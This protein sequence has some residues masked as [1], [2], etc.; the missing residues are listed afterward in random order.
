MLWL[1]NRNVRTTVTLLSKLPI[2]KDFFV[3]G[4]AIPDTLEVDEAETTS[5]KI[6]IKWSK[7]ATDA[8]AMEVA[9]DSDTTTLTDVQIEEFVFEDLPPGASGNCKVIVM[10]TLLNSDCKSEKSIP[11]STSKLKRLFQHTS[12]ICFLQNKPKNGMYNFRRSWFSHS[13]N[14]SGSRLDITAFRSFQR[15]PLKMSTGRLYSKL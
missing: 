15:P 1:D 9:F 3:E 10:G 5:T 8:P 14:T 7:P 13:S 4:G 6:K 11:C 2:K 12:K